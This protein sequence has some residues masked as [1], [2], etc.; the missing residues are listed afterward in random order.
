[1]LWGQ[2]MSRFGKE[3]RQSADGTETVILMVPDMLMWM[4][5]PNVTNQ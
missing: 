3:K 1:M 2:Q 4:F 5:F